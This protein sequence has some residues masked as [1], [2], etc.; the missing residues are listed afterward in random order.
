L[1]VF[2]ILGI[3][4]SRGSVW[5]GLVMAP[6]VADHLT[7]IVGRYQK[8]A[9]EG[10]QA[11]GL[12]VLN[13]T[14]LVLILFLG[15]ISLPWFKNMLPFPAAKAGLISAETPITATD[16]LLVKAP[17]RQVFNSMSFGS[18]LIWAA[19]PKYQVFTDSRIELFPEKVW[20][21]YLRIS[22]VE[23]DWEDLLRAYGVNTL[24]LSPSDQ[25]A[26]IKAVQ[27][28]ENWKMIYQDEVACI[29]VRASGLE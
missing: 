4:T 27:M 7:A 13:V 20:L 28:S 24:M 26:L 21:D 1:L 2:G 23:G 18:Y 12:R 29:F 8:P 10:D 3:R 19:Y 14:L 11:G 15:L 25:P 9:E 16:Q 17:P 22:N 5:F 6:I